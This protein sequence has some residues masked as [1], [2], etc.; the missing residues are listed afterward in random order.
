MYAVN[1]VYV[2]G[3][4]HDSHFVSHSYPAASP[5]YC[6]YQTA[7]YLLPLT[8]KPM[9]NCQMAGYVEYHSLGRFFYSL[10]QWQPTRSDFRCYL[11]LCDNLLL[12]IESAGDNRYQNDY[13][14]RLDSNTKIEKS[15]WSD[16]DFIVNNSHHFPCS[17]ERECNKWMTAITAAI[18]ATK[19]LEE[20]KGTEE[21]E[22]DDDRYAL[23]K[24]QCHYYVPRKE[25]RDM[26]T[27]T[28]SE[29]EEKE[30][31]DDE[32]SEHSAESSPPLTIVDRIQQWRGARHSN[33]LSVLNI[34]G[35]GD[36]NNHPRH[37]FVLSYHCLY[38]SP[39]DIRQYWFYKGQ[40]TRIADQEVKE[41]VWRKVFGGDDA[42]DNQYENAGNNQQVIVK[43]KKKK[44]PEIEEQKQEEEEKTEEEPPTTGLA[45]SAADI[46][47]NHKIIDRLAFNLSAYSSPEKRLDS[48]WV[49]SVTQQILA[50]WEVV[51]E[52]MIR[53]DFN[54]RFIVYSYVVIEHFNAN[55]CDPSE[56]LSLANIMNNRSQSA[57]ENTNNLTAI[58]AVHCGLFHRKEMRGG[59]SKS[60]EN[61][62]KVGAANGKQETDEEE[63][64]DAEELNG[65][66]TENVEEEEQG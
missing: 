63:E 10:K 54:Y 14:I 46:L 35:D 28:E 7:H 17:S 38:H 32:L 3:N 44:K 21:A 4:V 40:C 53:G 66:T 42:D 2:I 31:D 6:I 11:V 30:E 8:V 9:K 16:R 5:H 55:E 64:E 33:C 24:E 47:P 29:N 48:E 1:H 23:V 12:W 22:D 65:N 37:P 15:S 45:V 61:Q 20:N 18:K 41:R 43:V 60:N 59:R 34:S 50:D 27:E 62:V 57:A 51:N 39:S 36:D 13:C 52:K 26:E 19:S 56:C 25:C 58:D 49:A